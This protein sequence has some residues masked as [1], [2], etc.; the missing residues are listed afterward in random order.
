M[1]V[2]NDFVKGL[3]LLERLG[4]LWI[5]AVRHDKAVDQDNQHDRQAEKCEL[6]SQGINTLVR[7]CHKYTVSQLLV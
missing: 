2:F 5:R 7:A 3:Y 1:N 6:Y 4:C